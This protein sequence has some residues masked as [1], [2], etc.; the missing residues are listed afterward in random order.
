MKKAYF[1]ILL[2]ALLLMACATSPTGRRQFMIVSEDAAISASKQAYVEMLKPYEQQN[3]IDTD[4]ALKKRVYE[5]TG[6]LIAQA[7]K[8]R[9]ETK[10]WDWRIKI[11]DDPD[12]EIINGNTATADQSAGTGRAA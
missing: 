3:K 11:I 1:T 12:K 4:P 8:M 10:N 7:V 2:Y 9:P 5:I 6:R